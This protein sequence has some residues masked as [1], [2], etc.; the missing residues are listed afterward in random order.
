[1]ALARRVAAEAPTAPAHY[2]LGEMHNARGESADYERELGAALALDATYG[3]ARQSLAILL[4]NSG[5]NELADAQFHELA[6]RQPLDPTARLNYATFLLGRQRYAEAE[7]ELDR[8]LDLSPTY[9]KAQL[10]RVNLLL[11][12][13]R[14]TAARELASRIASQ[15]PDP[16]LAAQARRLGEA[17]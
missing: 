9:W 3:R 11:A 17:P 15:C 4:A 1:V 8:A 7:R 16:G 2:I 5:R 12:T 10:A 14:A 6:T 13:E